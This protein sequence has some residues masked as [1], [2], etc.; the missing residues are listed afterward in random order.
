VCPHSLPPPTL[1]IPVRG[2]RVP[3]PLVSPPSAVKRSTSA[4]STA[5]VATAASD[6]ASMSS[7][8]ADG[9]GGGGGAVDKAALWNAKALADDAFN[10][11]GKF[12]AAGGRG[13]DDGSG[14]VGGKRKTPT[15]T[16]TPTQ[17]KLAA[18]NLKGMKSMSAFF[19]AAPSPAPAPS[20]PVSAPAPAAADV[21]LDVEAADGGDS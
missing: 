17:K 10:M 20:I 12:L 21:Q 16:L 1:P 14:A 11:V 9:G 2:C 5:S 7:I 8:S 4:G 19:G 13:G 6:A 15:T 18:T 3:N